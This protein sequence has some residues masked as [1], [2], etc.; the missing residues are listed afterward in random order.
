MSTI[1]IIGFP[2]AGL[3]NDL[4]NF[5]LQDGVDIGVLSPDNFIANKFDSESRFINAVTKDLDL[6]LQI[7]NKLDQDSLQRFTFIHSTCVI[8]PSAQIGAGS[9]LG[10]FVGVYHQVVIGKDCVIAPYSM[11]SHRAQLGNNCMLNPGVLITGTTRV[12]D[13]CQFGVRSTVLDQ[14]TICDNVFVG[15]ASTI[16]KDITTPGRWVGSPA[17]QVL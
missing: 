5:I 14:L 4:L 3:V 9:F 11:I 13:N 6:R 15:A 2:Q 12:G 10:P 7:N 1:N 8:D 17:R 16:N